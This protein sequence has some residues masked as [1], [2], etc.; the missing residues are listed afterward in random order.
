MLVVAERESTTMDDMRQISAA[1]RHLDAPVVGMA[2]TEGGVEIYDWGR[3]DTGRQ[4][5]PQLAADERDP[6]A[7]IPITDSPETPPLE[8][9]SVAEH[10]PREV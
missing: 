4:D 2:L 3:V 5:S 1:L 6:T 8:E 10:A 9:L 7:Q